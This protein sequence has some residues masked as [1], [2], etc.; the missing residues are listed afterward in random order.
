MATGATAFAKSVRQ[1]PDELLPDRVQLLGRNRGVEEELH[2][3]GIPI[4]D[5]LR[6]D[7]RLEEV[8][9]STVDVC[10]A[11]TATLT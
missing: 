2:P 7:N 11:S 6:T 4:I 3:D 5:P 1:Q 9:K 10:A 8:L